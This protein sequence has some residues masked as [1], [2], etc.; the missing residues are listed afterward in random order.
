[1]APEGPR[2]GGVVAAVE[3]RE[4]GYA[5]R[6][7]CLLVVLTTAKTITLIALRDGVAGSLWFPVAYYWQDVLTALLF[8]AAD[9]LIGRPVV[10]WTAYAAIAIYAALNVAITVVLSS[11]LTPA[12]VRASG[13]ALADSV[14]HYL[15]PV[16]V[17]GCLLP[18]AAAT[19]APRMLAAR[20]ARLPAAARWIAVSAAVLVV[21][22]GPLASSR[23]ETRG[24]H[25]N[26][27]GALVETSVVRIAPA[28]HSVDWRLSPFAG[29]SGGEPLDEYVGIARGRNVV[30][31]ALESTAARYL[32]LYGASVDPAPRLRALARDAIVFDR[33]YAVYPE[34]IKGL[35]ATL[36]SRYPAFDT[37]AEIYEGVEC[38]S[39][40]AKLQNAGYATAL[41]HSG[42]F[43]YLGMRAVIDRRGFGV[44]EDAG[45]IGGNV[46]SSFGVDEPATVR[47]ML[48][49][50]D[51]RPPNSPFFVMYLPIAGHHPYFT[52]GPRTF[53]GDS[54]FA[55][56]LNAVHEG[57]E[58]LGTLIDGLHSRGLH[59]KTLF[60]VYGDHG[61][62]FG[63]HPGNFAHTLFAYDEN[64]RVPL[65]IAAPGAIRGSTHVARVASVVDIA[66]T[67]DALLGLAAA[68]AQDGHSLLAAGARMA[69]VFTDYSL[70]WLGLVDGCWKYLLEIDTNRSRL[71]DVCADP[72][73]TRDRAGEF[74]ERTTVYGNRVRQ[75]AE[76][77]KA[78]LPG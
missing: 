65:V 60:V 42:R 67:V 36:C 73:E 12:L 23:T 52:H 37:P 47:R 63:Q 7:V 28:R 13:G 31:V 51:G 11:P 22:L 27:L 61:E 3:A 30:L 34:S 39:L 72:D 49:W 35:F 46:R 57:D 56:Y 54:D 59:D 66:P 9:R 20:V 53:A 68:P 77:Q 25:R 5:L 45:A 17:I 55:S 76:A 15:T 16:N 4:P 38:A 78:R 32:G 69:F 40:A 33:A 24:L 18:L 43:D 44:L 8:A 70:G 14:R 62:A 21:C 6:A 26:A 64:V 58:A 2:H 75:W 74:H 71:F 10:A 19:M 50:I 29:A 41:F 48:A 1:M